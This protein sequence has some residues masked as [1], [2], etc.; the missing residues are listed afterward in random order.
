MH[1]TSKPR[2][3][4]TP[5]STGPFSVDEMQAILK[6]VLKRGEPPGPTER[7]RLV[8][9]LNLIRG[10]YLSAQEGAHEAKQAAEQNRLIRRLQGSL[11]RRHAGQERL[12]ELL[13][14]LS[15]CAALMRELEAARQPLPVIKNSRHLAV[16]T[17]AAFRLA[18]APD[19]P[20]VTYLGSRSVGRR[21]EIGGDF[22]RLL[23]TDSK[24]VSMPRQSTAAP[25]RR[26]GSA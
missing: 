5:P 3:A 26:R 23:R 21:S 20:G 10:A 11:A 24:R 6:M 17:A 9:T 7:A 19:N 15:D 18:M 13:T 25:L 14:K 8:A 16:S 4:T 2:R 12:P 1:V 22:R